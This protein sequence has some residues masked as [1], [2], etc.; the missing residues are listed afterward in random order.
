MKRGNGFLTTGVKGLDQI[1]KGGFKVNSCILVTGVPGSGKTIFGLQFVCEGARNGEHC[2]M[3]LTEESAESMRSY[4]K[5]LGIDL[6]KYEKKGLI[7]LVEQR[8]FGGKII[9]MQL[10]FNLIKKNKISR[11]VLDSLSIFEY[12]FKS[13]SDEYKKGLLQFLYDI[14]SSG[15]TFLAVAERQTTSLDNLH[16]KPED[17]L[18]DG[19]VFLTK[20]R[21]GASFERCL[22]IIKL[23]GQEHGMDIYP[24]KINSGGITVYPKEIPFSLSENE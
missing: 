12:I 4:S 15:I 23:K 20:I 21:K 13:G 5:A 1:C 17:S 14:K 2:M 22:N 16:Y 3:I 19:M 7:T 8:L 18:F 6:E 9:S 11:L 10:P 24:F